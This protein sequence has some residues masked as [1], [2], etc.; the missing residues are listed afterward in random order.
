M[1]DI[2]ESCIQMANK[3]ASIKLAYYKYN[4]GLWPIA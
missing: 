3:K 2:V 1:A 4:A